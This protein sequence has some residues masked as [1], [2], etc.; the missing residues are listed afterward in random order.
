MILDTDIMIDMFR[1]D[2]QV[3][4]KVGQLKNKEVVLGTTSINTFELYRGNTLLSSKSDPEALGQLL[5]YL[6]IYS[7]SF[8]ASKKA[9]E[10]LNLL[11]SKG[12]VIELPDIMIASIC[13]ANN[14]PLLTRNIKHFS[15]IDG[16]Q[17][18]SL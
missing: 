8:Y 17:L 14:Q 5:S 13:I 7:F 4:K 18:E 11:K 12:E 9:A 10:I 16:L 3:M 15:R 6:Q 1:D 2:K